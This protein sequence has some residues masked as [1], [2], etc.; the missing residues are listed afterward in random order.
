MEGKADL[1]EEII[2][3]A[4]LDRIEPKPLTRGDAAIAKATLTP[5]QKR[6]RLAKRALATRGLVEAVTWSFIPHDDAVPVRR[7]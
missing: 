3:I 7:R 1:V 2:R 6:T 4:G 5:L